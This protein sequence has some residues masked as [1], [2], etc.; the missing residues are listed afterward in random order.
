MATARLWIIHS[1][2]SSSSAFAV[3]VAVVAAHTQHHHKD[4]GERE[5][6]FFK[7]G[8]WSCRSSLP[9][10]FLPL[11]LLLPSHCSRTR[12]MGNA[13]NYAIRD[14]MIHRLLTNGATDGRT[15]R[16]PLEIFIWKRIHLTSEKSISLSSISSSSPPSA[17][18][19][20]VLYCTALRALNHRIFS[21]I[22]PGGGLAWHLASSLSIKYSPIHRPSTITQ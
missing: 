4:E 3:A 9:F 12:I 20:F 22:P 2:S 21:Q 13:H 10:T 16:D 7:M 11:L 19:L 1:S 14:E 5:A 15:D 18:L 17:R 8:M 6:A